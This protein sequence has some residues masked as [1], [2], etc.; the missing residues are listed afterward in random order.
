MNGTGN[1]NVPTS[2]LIFGDSDATVA[3][4]RRETLDGD[5]RVFIF[6]GLVVGLISNVAITSDD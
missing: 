6:G 5:G 4:K 1:A 2:G 3:G